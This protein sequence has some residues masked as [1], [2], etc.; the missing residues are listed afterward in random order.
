MWPPVLLSE[1]PQVLQIAL[2]I[3]GPVLTGAIGGW[4]LGISEAGYV[5]WTTV[6]I[7]GGIGVGMEHATPRGGALR[8]VF[9]GAL[10]AATIL[11]VH[12]LI[13]N[14]AKASLPHP[15]SLIIVIFAVIS[16]LL[17]LLGVRLRRR[18]AAPAA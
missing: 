2:P 16:T 8:G 11:A 17:G 12:E 15:A 14:D 7:L 5:I 6:M 9:G 1:R 10:F 3:A 13:G 18:F 4:L